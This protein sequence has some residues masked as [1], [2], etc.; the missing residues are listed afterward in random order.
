MTENED[1]TPSDSLLLGDPIAAAKVANPYAAPGL[2]A[3]GVVL[4]DVEDDEANEAAAA[5]TLA[6]LDEDE[7]LVEHEDGT[8]EDDEAE[9]DPADPE[10]VDPDV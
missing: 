5:A 3:A 4:P 1:W 10:P 9:D 2:S 8:V 7:L 6:Q